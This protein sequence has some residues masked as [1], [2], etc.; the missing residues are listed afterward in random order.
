MYKLFLFQWKHDEQGLNI[1]TS[2]AMWP[3]LS[4]N[5][6]LVNNRQGNSWLSHPHTKLCYRFL[7]QSEENGGPKK[8]CHSGNCD[9]AKGILD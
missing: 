6:I 1:D 7:G 9:W 3:F 4:S 5:P 2:K 8:K